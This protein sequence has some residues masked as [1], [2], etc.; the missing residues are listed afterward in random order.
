[1]NRALDRLSERMDKLDDEIWAAE[2]A[3]NK[4]A[5]IVGLRE[6]ARAWRK[7]GEILEKAGRDSVAASLSAQR[8]ENTAFQLEGGAL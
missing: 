4:S 8:D 1:M 3:G 6:R 5:Q 2:K 7:Y